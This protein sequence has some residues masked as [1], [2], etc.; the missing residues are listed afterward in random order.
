M[1]VWLLMLAAQAVAAVELA[2]RLGTLFGFVVFALL[3]ASTM[4][5]AGYLLHT[6]TTGE[7]T[8]R[9]RLAGLFLPWSLL[10][11]QGSLSA[12]LL[13]NLLASLAWGGVMIACYRLNWVLPSSPETKMPATVLTIVASWLAILCR[14]VLL[15]GW[16]LYLRSMYSRR[17]QSISL[18]ATWQ[19]LLIP[20]LAIVASLVLG[21]YGYVWLAL[22][23]VG[24][25]LFIVL[26]PLLLMFAAIAYMTL[27]GKKI[28]WN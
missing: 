14:L 21:H 11:G 9:N 15:G 6:S 20:P 5:L 26:T 28:R 8:W 24:L 7:V 19:P 10:A 17:S 1:I 18:K 13:K 3:I 25:P 16:L 12:L 2:E 4:G 23:S 27:T 22:L